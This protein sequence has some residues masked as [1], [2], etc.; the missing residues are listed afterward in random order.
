MHR[1]LSPSDPDL[2][3][4]C[5]HYTYLEHMDAIPTEGFIAGGRKGVRYRNHI[6][7]RS[8]AP[9]RCAGRKGSYE[10]ACSI[11]LRRALLMGF[12]F[13]RSD[14]DVILSPGLRGRLPP[15]LITKIV[16]LPSGAIRYPLLALPPTASWGSGSGGDAATARPATLPAGPAC[17]SARPTRCSQPFSPRR[18]PAPSCSPCARPGG[19]AP[20]AAP[21]DVLGTGRA[22]EV[23]AARV[24]QAA[25]RKALARSR[26]EALR[27]RR[28]VDAAIYIQ[29][30]YRAHLVRRR[31]AA[32]LLA[33][34]RVQEA[35]RH[36]LARGRWAA[37]R[38]APPAPRAP[39]AARPTA[40][41]FPLGS[42]LPAAPRPR[43]STATPRAPYVWLAAASGKLWV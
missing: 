37:P 21:T 14:D 30:F 35:G 17:P 11:D 3:T 26:A 33:A 42:E 4:Q 18:R 12:P 24:I 22:Q 15:G 13:F 28:L 29:A 34:T 8:G 27:V 40:A 23:R 5:L 25:F 32:R 9:P 43:P 2:P 16:D 1:R 19:L 6:Y 10:I 31:L 20:R 41:R 39:R 38:A 7:F 36:Y